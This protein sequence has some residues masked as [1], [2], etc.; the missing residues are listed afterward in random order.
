M[1]LVNFVAIAAKWL[2]YQQTVFVC[3][4]TA[5]LVLIF[6]ETEVPQAV[7]YN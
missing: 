7:I 6:I 5:F 4:F 2:I 3:C 1:F